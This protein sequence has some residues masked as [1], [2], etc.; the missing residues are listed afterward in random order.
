VNRLLIIGLIL[1]AC[2]ANPADLILCGGVQVSVISLQK[3]TT[4]KWAWV[5]GDSPSIP[6]E[7]RAKFRSTD[8]CKSYSGGLLLITSSSG[9]VALIDRE[10]KKCLFLAESRN[11][12]S[13]CLL[14]DRQIAV[15]A[16]YGGDEIQFFDRKDQQ[17]PAKPVQTIPFRG[18]HGTVFDADRNCLWTL[19]DSEL[20]QL[21]RRKNG[22]WSIK[23]AL[24]LPTQGGH[25][26]SRVHD[27]RQLYVT[28]GT[29][30]LVFDREQETFAVHP[31]IGD[32]LKVKS[33]DRHPETGRIVFHQGTQNTWWSDTILFVGGNPVKLPNARLYKVRWDI[34]RRIP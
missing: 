11:A 26:L 22:H 3:P 23:S 17:R 25:D 19:G 2:E 14:P 9:G 12:H 8:E 27:G 1:V 28:S 7:F 24:K 16:S 32:R 13:A 4:P 18:A 15:A 34:P 5:A 21:T 31:T 6:A 10:T 33:V 29:Q 30:V 20:A